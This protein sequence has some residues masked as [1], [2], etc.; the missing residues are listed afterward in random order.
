MKDLLLIIS[1]IL[2][3]LVIWLLKEIISGQAKAKIQN[4]KF[5]TKK[6]LTGITSIVRTDLWGKTISHELSIRTWLVRLGII[7]VIIGV[8]YGYG[9]WRGTQGV[10]PILDWRGKEEW[11]SLNEHYLHI[12]K[13]GTMEV[14]DKDKKTIL[15]KITVKD[16]ANLKKNLRPYGIDVKLMGVTGVG[17]GQTIDKEIGVGLNILKFYDWRAGIC[18]TQKG[19]YIGVDYKLE[20]WI[21]WMHNSYIGAGYGRGYVGDS[22]I[23]TKFSWEF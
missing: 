11:V 23:L 12:C 8:I 3:G 6:L 21:K 19:A 4:E 10:Q 7:G 16:L 22:R 9:W 13:D 5:D 1:G 14:M 20:K 2:A 18:A 17:V 15:K